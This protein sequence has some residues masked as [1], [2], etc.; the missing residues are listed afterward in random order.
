M[1][2]PL[3]G[4]HAVSSGRLVLH[5]ICSLLS[6]SNS[7]LCFHS[8]PA[9][10]LLWSTCRLSPTP[11]RQTAQYIP[12]TL[13]TDCTIYPQHLIDRL[14]N[15]SPTP[16][17]QT[18]Q[19]IPTPT[20]YRQTAQYIPNTLSTDCTICPQHLIDRL[21]NTSPTPYR[22]TAQYIPNTLSTDCAI[23]PQHRIDRLHKV[24]NAAA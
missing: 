20:P 17:R 18:A 24:H 7:G 14:H 3:A 16:Y 19:Y 9:G 11:Y 10:L 8:A 1:Y 13:S 12:N 6:D 22:Q 5:E 15:I 21:R 23:Y 4:Q 2:R